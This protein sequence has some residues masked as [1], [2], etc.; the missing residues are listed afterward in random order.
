M[1][2]IYKITN[3]INNKSY[4][5]Q[6]IK[7]ESRW[8]EHKREAFNPKN[9]NYNRAFYQAIRKYGL[10]NFKF[11]I[12]EECNIEELDEKEKYWIAFY[13]TFPPELGKGYN[14]Y[15]GGS[16]NYPK[17]TNEQVIEIISLL[18]NTD[19]ST[20]EIANKYNICTD[21]ITGINVGRMYKINGYEYPIRIKHFY[22]KE[23]SPFYDGETICPICGGRMASTS[24]RC[25]K[26]N[27]K[28]RNRITP[29]SY[30]ELFTSLYE[31][32]NME[33]V[34][35]KYNVSSLLIQKWC[36]SYGINPQRKNE[37]IERYEVEFLGK[38][39]KKHIENYGTKVAKLDPD[40]KEIIQIFKNKAQAIKSCNSKSSSSITRACNTGNKA[41]GYYWKYIK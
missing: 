2:G 15:P 33:R 38:E 23:G 31:L 29:P 6:S 27:N 7:I 5:G 39:P 37:Y 11:E 36:R 8:E 18:K 40:T 20:T 25:R 34:A 41:L 24:K 1:I 13:Q 17:L 3:L 28:I 10:D 19:L 22:H 14:L 32:R 16:G 4:I 12:V 30:E 26:C 9:R 21:L 35:Q